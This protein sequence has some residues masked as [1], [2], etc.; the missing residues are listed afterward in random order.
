MAIAL[1]G[2]R[3][4]SQAAFLPPPGCWAA[5]LGRLRRVPRR[6]LGVPRH[7]AAEYRAATG[8]V[9]TVAP[10]SRPL[11]AAQQE[12]LQA[13]QPREHACT[14]AHV[15]KIVLPATRTG[16]RHHLTTRATSPPLPV[17]S[18]SPRQWVS[19]SLGSVSVFR[20]CDVHL[21]CVLAQLRNPMAQQVRGWARNGRTRVDATGGCRAMHATGRGAEWLTRQLVRW[22]HCVAPVCM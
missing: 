20:P 1:Y 9:C 18:L 19:V 4:V 6:G 5:G 21:R 2:W 17:P 8:S 3:H 16:H 12:R 7:K 13:Q 11:G 22:R 15:H 14:E 10:F